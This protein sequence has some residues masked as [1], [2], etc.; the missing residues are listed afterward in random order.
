MKR[1]A[2]NYES[3]TN[4]YCQL[5]FPF[6]NSKNYL[7]FFILLLLF[8]PWTAS[9]QQVKQIVKGSVVSEKDE[10]LPG[11]SIRFK[12][13]TAATITD[14]K[15]GYSIEV[16]NG[17]GSLFFTT[18][19][20]ES[21]TEQIRNRN[22]INIKLTSSSLALDQVVVVG[23]S[24]HK[25][26]DLTG[27]VSIVSAKEIRKSEPVN[28]E[29]ALKGK[30]AGVQV[31]N[32]DGAPGSGINV[33]IRGANSITAGSSPLY[34]VDGFPYPISSDPLNNPLSTLSPDV[35]SDITV[36]KDVSST[37]I[38]GA[39]GANGVVLITTKKAK[40]GVNE[41][42]LKTTY[43]VSKLTKGLEMLDPEGYM[44]AMMLEYTFFNFWQ[45]GD[46]YNDY[47]NQIWKTDPSRFKYYSDFLFKNSIRQLSEVTYTGGSKNV[48]NITTLSFLDDKGIVYNTGFKRY[49]FASNTSVQA[50]PRF[51]ISANLAYNNM[52]RS[53]STYLPADA[54]GNVDIFNTISTYSPLIPKEWTWREYD[55]NLH[56]GF[57]K[58]RDNPYRLLND[59]EASTID[60]L[61]TGQLDLNYQLLKGLDLKGGVGVRLPQNEAKKFVPQTIYSSFLT[62]G[63][64]QYD[65]GKSTNLRYYAQ[66]NYNKTFNE[67]HEVTA[68][69]VGESNNY[70]ADG[71]SQ[72]YTHFNTDLGFN[73]IYTAQSG[74]FVKPPLIT[75][76]EYQIL[77]GIAF[78]TYSYKEKYLFK[79]SVRSDGS[80]RFGPENRWGIFPAAAAAWR[81]SEE[82]WFK[83]SKTLSK[84]VSSAKFRASYGEVGNDQIPDYLWVNT[85]GYSS[86]RAVFFA[87]GTP[88]ANGIFTSATPAANSALYTV[89]QSNKEIEW[90]TTKEY[91]FGLDL[92][93][94]DNRINMVLDVY[95]RKTVNML[96]NQTLP[97]T[98][99]FESVTR[100]I[101][102]IRNKGIEL[103]L[104]AGVIRN[105]DFRWDVTFNIS[106]NRSKVLDLGD[107]D[108]MLENRNVGSQAYSGQNVLIKE[109]MPLGLLFG[110][111][112]EGMRTTWNLDNNAPQSNLYYWTGTR[113]GPFGFYTFNDTNGDGWIDLDDRSILAKTEP[114]FIGGI[115]TTIGYKFL[116][117]YLSFSGSYGSDLVNANYY[118]LLNQL[119]GSNNKVKMFAEQGWFPTS[120]RGGTIPGPGPAYFG[121]P[122]YYNTSSD[123]VEDGSY[124]KLNNIALSL[125]VPKSLLKRIKMKT[126]RL[127]YTATNLFTITRYSGY[128]PEVS[129][130]KST[131]GT[132]RILPG[133]DF[134]SYP[135]SRTHAITL[136][137]TF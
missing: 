3:L 49:N 77:S 127:T 106:A 105:R 58:Q 125:D 55:A 56:T 99:G 104:N 114:S 75:A 10:A 120:N 41:L 91:N 88:D 95:N 9:S 54:P 12:G 47:R 34:V 60:R 61:F 44:R 70:K 67:I 80:S 51:N 108:L 6:R 14:D 5:W 31:Q 29:Q 4:N 118:E 126:L 71:F 78:A 63:E 35:I 43:G 64:A 132:S 137:L 113:E 131:D 39:Q 59:I 136:N 90:E 109:G 82:G 68:G 96:L 66:V 33:K 7:P 42:S 45:N 85:L 72:E 133:V 32:S 123:F 8:Q 115:S 135:Y 101:G 27:A 52:N 25:K 74:D 23:Y 50:T 98:S 73:G 116:E 69:L 102:S 124:L 62:G 112:I 119:I 92:G 110:M 16:P 87:P 1:S 79:A 94:L 19:G 18:V 86:R 30:I 97:L 134:S 53:G 81:I 89:K 24:A 130:A 128:D 122:Q 21:Y 121:P 129:S 11:V 93:F 20:Y 28:I 84:I 100:N 37:S 40:D 48:R 111:Q 83:N 22:I 107:N 117:L 13:G 65:I 26:V 46:F 17:N 36:L 38:Y 103:G 15:G 2:T 76:S 57:F